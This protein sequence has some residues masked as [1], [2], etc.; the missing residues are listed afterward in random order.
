MSLKSIVNKLTGKIGLHESTLKEQ[1]T[2]KT[3]DGVTVNY[4]LVMNTAFVAVKGDRTFDDKQSGK[5]ALTIGSAAALKYIC[6]V[7]YQDLRKD[8]GGICE[9][10]MEDARDSTMKFAQRS[11]SDFAMNNIVD[12]A[13][14]FPAVSGSASASAKRRAEAQAGAA[15]AAQAATQG[16]ASGVQVHK[17]IRLKKT[18]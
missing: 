15:A 16:V 3:S 17:P 7:P 9:K 14:T 5:M 4:E 1:C 13:G 12:A 8:P 2:A 6:T 18:P 10:A 11:M